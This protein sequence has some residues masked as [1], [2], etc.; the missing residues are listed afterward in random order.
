M[1]SEVLGAN[2]PEFDT[3]WTPCYRIIHSIYPPIHFYERLSDAEDWEVL[4]E[5]ERLTNPRILDE[6]GKYHLIRPEDRHTGPQWGWVNAAFTFLKE[7]GSRFSNGKFGVYYAGKE[8]E[9]SIAETKYHREI[10][11]GRTSE[12]AMSIDMSVI[13]ANLK[14]Q[15]R[16]LR[17]LKTSH[18]DIYHSTNYALPQR[19][20]E[21]LREKNSYGVLY[22]SVRRAKGECVGIFRPP[23]LSE[24][25][26]QKYLVYEWDGHSINQIYEKKVVPPDSYKAP[27]T[28]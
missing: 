18:S 17:G 2:I 12:P 23:V 22:S 7:E 13:T 6:I 16:D 25:V 21:E 27:E 15:L 14:G 1:H 28:L 20:G 9:T 5:I 19:L 26:H 3:E 10:F 11:Y 4:V 8:L 24:P